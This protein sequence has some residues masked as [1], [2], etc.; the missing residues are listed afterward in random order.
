MKLKQSELRS[1]VREV[2]VEEGN[3]SKKKKTKRKQAQKKK[4]DK[5]KEAKRLGQLW[6]ELNV[7]DDELKKVLDTLKK[8]PKSV[9]K[10]M[11]ALVVKEES[12]N[13]YGL[14]NDPK[15]LSLVEEKKGKGFND[16]PFQRFSRIVVVLTL[17]FGLYNTAQASSAASIS[18]DFN[19]PGYELMGGGDG[20][21]DGKADSANS[22]LRARVAAAASEAETEQKVDA[23][24]LVTGETGDAPAGNKFDNA[25]QERNYAQEMEAGNKAYAEAKAADDAAVSQIDGLIDQVLNPALTEQ[26]VGTGDVTIGDVDYSLDLDGT[27][28]TILADIL[29]AGGDVSVSDVINAIGPETKAAINELPTGLTS[30]APASEVKE[31]HANHMLSLVRAAVSRVSNS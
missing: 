30:T 15:I 28:S 10:Y 3:G 16:T 1:L 23:V 19:R 18:E 11:E 4:K 24:D 2:L 14:H 20:D 25:G 27:E 7:T 12:V 13:R 8:D 6:K 26:P 17:A 22:D 21:G 29:D 9:K 5:A 31:A